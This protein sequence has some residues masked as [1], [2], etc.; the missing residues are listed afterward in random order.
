MSPLPVKT[1]TMVH[2][3]PGEL[4]MEVL[5]LRILMAVPKP[6]VFLILKPDKRVDT[7]FRIS[8]VPHHHE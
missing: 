3:R 6:H 8:V 4:I 2:L 1:R 7:E 5:M